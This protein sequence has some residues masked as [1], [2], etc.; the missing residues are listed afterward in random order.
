MLG[1]LLGVVV[2]FDPLIT[3]YLLRDFSW[4]HDLPYL[5]SITT[6]LAIGMAFAMRPFV[7]GI[8]TATIHDYWRFFPLLFLLAYQFTGLAAGPLD[9]T[10]ILIGVFMLLFMAG[11]FIRR[12]QR[13]VSTPFNMLHLVF[14]ICLAVSLVSEFKPT[15]FLRS[16]KPFVLFFL[17]VNFLPRENL[18]PT[19]VRWLLVLAMLSAAFGL[20]QELVWLTTQKTLSLLSE[21]D[22]EMMVETHF[23]VP[24][25]RVPAMMTGYRPF[26]L[27]LGIAMML[28]V[29][30]LLW[31]K[32]GALL[33]PRWLILG[34]CFIVPALVL[35]LSKDMLL[36]ASAGLLLLLL[37]Y[38]PKRFVPLALLT[39]LAGT[40]VLLVAIAI[41]PGNIDTAVDLT[42]TVPK[43]E[44]ERIRLDRDSIE[45]FMHGPHLWTGRGVFSGYRY[46]AHTRHWPAHNAFILVAAEVGVAG[47]AVFLLIYGLAI[48]RVVALNIVVRD[49]PY[50]P[51]VRSLLAIMVVILVGAQFE[52]DYL[53]MF[54]WAIFATAE[55]TW[56]LLRRNAVATTGP[57]INNGTG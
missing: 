42:R 5:L 53:E 31:W 28:S 24:I 4:L 17:L 43:S 55:A 34:L 11:L 44:V 38:K 47:L 15:G 9:A 33:R 40:L 14:I 8:A 3:T 36:G 26:A 22:L 23:G 18:I 45:G 12:D 29:S 39:G 50:L 54:I 32:Q 56:F 46:T 6:A 57:P 13:F 25:F 27:Y 7:A 35:T 16:L 30:A 20:V 37:M 51:I 2:V 41:V 49:G 48:A 19:F 10:D 1:L 52:A 21:K